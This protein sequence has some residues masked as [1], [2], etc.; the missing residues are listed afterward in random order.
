M[1]K[2]TRKAASRIQSA[3]CSANGGTTK[4]GSFA[5]RAM[6]AAYTNEPLN[7][8]M[9]ETAGISSALVKFG[10]FALA[11]AAAY[12]HKDNLVETFS[13]WIGNS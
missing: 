6:S 11:G 9:S 4:A 2:M 7:K 5:A 3:A 1:T 10:F 13:N 12:Y 8:P